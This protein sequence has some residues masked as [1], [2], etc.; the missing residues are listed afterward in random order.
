MGDYIDRLV[1]CV[2]TAADN[3]LAN[4]PVVIDVDNEL[5]LAGIFIVASGS[6]ARQVKAI[7][8]EIMDEVAREIGERPSHIEGREESRWVLLDYG[9]VVVHVLVDEDREYYSLES[10]WG[11]HP[12][13]PLVPAGRG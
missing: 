3:K 10:L 4:N 9:D 6:T 11:N 8:E 1:E 13:R 7:S 2:A 5:G 12:I